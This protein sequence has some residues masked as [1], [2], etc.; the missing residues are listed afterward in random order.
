MSAGVRAHAVALIAALEA[1]VAVSIAWVVNLRS[2]PRLGLEASAILVFLPI[3]LLILFGMWL[4]L[5]FL[6]VRR[7]RWTGLLA[8][9][10]S[11]ALGYLMV[12]A[13]CGPVACFQAGPNRYMGWFL[14]LGI[15][16]AALAHHLALTPF[17]KKNPNG[18]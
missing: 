5:R 15:A 14:V 3:G 1:L 13:S 17:N 11:I 18:S 7:L 8:L 12:A 10:G 2:G 9:A 16:L 6:L 4:V